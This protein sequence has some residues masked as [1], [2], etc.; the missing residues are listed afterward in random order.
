M[1]EIPLTQ[2]FVAL[3]DDADFEAIN[4]F[5]WCVSKDR[6]GFYAQRR[7][8][9]SGGLWTTQKLHQ[10][11][12]SGAKQI[13]HRDGDGLNNQ[14]NNLRVATHQQNMRGF[15]RKAFGL[16]SG[17]RGVSWHK[18]SRSWV[19]QIQG[20]YLGTFDIEIE[21]AKAYDARAIK[22]FGDFATPNFPAQRRD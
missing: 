21:A 4:A 5:N 14:R 18:A 8:Q 16:T 22:L 11:L 19:A 1:K 15:K 6:R 7:V 3:V 12:I 13:D 9:K 10:F 17:F 2:G 20:R